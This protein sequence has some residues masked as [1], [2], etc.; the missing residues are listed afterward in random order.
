MRNCKQIT[1]LLSQQHDETPLSF[2]QRLRVHIHLSMCRD[3][4]E[5]RKQIDT[6]ERGL[7]QMFDGKKAE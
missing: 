1:R 6:I 5:Y 2:K 7:R 4:R 3:C